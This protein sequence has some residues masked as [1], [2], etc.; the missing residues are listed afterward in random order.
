MKKL[1][2]SLTLL[3]TITSFAQSPMG[4]DPENLVINFNEPGSKYF[5]LP[6]QRIKL[7]TGVELEYFEQGERSG[8][9]IIFL[10]GLSDSWHSFEP[11]LSHLPTSFHAFSITQRGHG[12][13]ERPAEGYTPKH[14]AA[15]VAAFIQQ[16][17]L[18]SAIVVGHS[19]GGVNTQQFAIDYP[20][21]AKAIVIVDSDADFKSNTGIKEFYN[22]VMKLEGSL[23]WD[24]MNGFQEACIAK[25]I[26]S[27]FYKLLVEEGTKTPVRVFQAALK[28]IIETD[29]STQLKNIQCPALIIWGDKDGFVFRKGQETF[30]K[31]IRKVT[32]LEYKGV[33]HSPQWEQPERFSADLVNFIHQNFNRTR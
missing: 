2:L 21:L 7:N 27:S 16:K 3:W 15:D 28:G 25:P 17:N 19:M 10:H 8:M 33:G 29:F 13:S 5:R 22:D 14:F 26:D 20:K 11:V 24:F 9:P 31:N 6:V 4:I 12:D 18:G 30:V 1:L 23:S 32:F